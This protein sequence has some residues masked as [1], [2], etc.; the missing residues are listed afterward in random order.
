ML[1]PLIRTIPNLSGNVKIAC[2]LSNFNKIDA[3]SF[4]SIV[5]YAKLLPISNVLAQ[6]QCEVNLMNS[7]YE[8]DLKMFY[9]MYSNTFYNT[10]FTY[11]HKIYGDGDTTK[12]LKNR[13][14]DF[15][16]GLKRVSYKKNGGSQFAFFAP[17]WI[18]SQNDL[19][20]YFLLHINIDKYAHTTTKTIKVL[21]NDIERKDKFNY[22]SLYLNKYAKNL[23]TNVVFCTP[24]T[25]QA[26][27]FGID[28]LHGGFVKKVDNII[29]KNYKFQST[30][31]KFDLNITEGFKRNKLCIKQ[32]MP[33]CFMFSLEDILT[34]YEITKY[35]GSKIQIYGEY[36]KNGQQVKMYDFSTD[37]TLLGQKSW[38]MRNG[39]FAVQDT[40]QN[41]M[42]ISFPSLMEA[43]YQGYE[44]FNKI[45]KESVRWK[46]KYSSDEHPYITNMSPAFSIAQESTCKYREF[47][48]SFSQI[49][50]YDDI[51]N[52]IVSP[53]TDN[54]FYKNDKRALIRYKT[55]MQNNASNWFNVADN[56]ERYT[57]RIIYNLNDL[58]KRNDW[59]IKINGEDINNYIS[60]SYNGNLSNLDPEYFENIQPDNNYEGE[61]FVRCSDTDLRG[62]RNAL[63][64]NMNLPENGSNGNAPFIIGNDESLSYTLYE[65]HTMFDDEENWSNVI[66]NKV[67]FKGILY[68]LSKIYAK[69]PNIN[70][71]TKFG[72]FVDPDMDMIS[73][74]KL[75]DIKSAHFTMF[76]D[77]K[78][79]KHLNAVQCTYLKSLIAGQN[80]FS[81][82]YM[83]ESSIG[84]RM[85]EVS[86]DSLFFEN[87]SQKD[88]QFLDLTRLGYDVYKLNLYFEL[89]EVIRKY[90]ELTFKIY[91]KTDERIINGY[92]QLPIYRLSQV[93]YDNNTLWFESHKANEELWIKNNLFFNL[94]NNQNKSKYDKKAF[95][96]IIA[97]YE[98]YMLECPLL[99]ESQFVSLYT[100]KKL[101]TEEQVDNVYDNCTQYLFN[102]ILVD[103]NE[104][105]G[106]N[107]FTEFKT[108]DKNYGD[109]LP[110]ERK[111]EDIDFIYVDPYN[112]ANVLGNDW[113]S[114]WLEDDLYSLDLYAKFLNKIHLKIYFG[115]LYKDENGEQTIT[116]QDKLD[117]LF[118]KR[119]ILFNDSENER[120]ELKDLYMNILDFYD[121]TDLH[122]ISRK[123][124][125]DLIF[126]EDTGTWSFS[127]E[128]LNSHDIRTLLKFNENDPMFDNY[129]FELVFKRT[130]LKVNKKIWNKININNYDQ[131]TDL[132]LYRISREDDYPA[133]LKYQCAYDLTLSSESVESCYT[134]Q[135]LFTSVFIKNQKTATIYSEYTQSKISYAT[136]NDEH[137]YR[138]D[139]DNTPFVLDISNYD[140]THSLIYGADNT[141]YYSYA[142]LDNLVSSYD[143]YE[144]D[145]AFNYVNRLEQYAGTISYLPTL[146]MIDRSESNVALAHG[147]RQVLQYYA[148][149]SYN[150]IDHIITS[151]TAYYSP[152]EYTRI[153]FNALDS[154]LHVRLG[155][156]N[157]TLLDN[158]TTVH[159]YS[160]DIFEDDV[161][162]Y[163]DL[164]AR[165]VPEK[166]EYDDLGI[167]DE[168]GISTY[169]VT[170]SYNTYYTYT[171]PVKETITIDDGLISYDT[172]RYVTTS[173]YETHVGY[174]TYGMIYIDAKFNNTNTSF[175]LIDKH[176]NDKKYFTYVNN[177]SIY[178]NDFSIQRDFIEF[179]PFM[180]FDLF[181]TLKSTNFVVNPFV[182]TI[183]A[184]NYP[185]QLPNRN[186]YDITMSYKPLCN[187]TLERYFDS[188]TPLITEMSNTS[189]TY[190]IKLENS[191]R[192]IYA[193]PQRDESVLY[194]ENVN[195]YNNNGTRL[196]TDKFN[197]ERVF[198]I[199]DK[200][201]NDNYNVNL[202]S[203]ITIKVSDN[204]TYEQMVEAEKYENVLRLFASYI[205]RN[206]DYDDNE[207]LFLYNKY[208]VSYDSYSTGID[209][210]RICKVYSLTIIFDL[211]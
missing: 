119:R 155:D 172:I 89:K 84:K 1:K 132:Y 25:N 201:F 105:Y 10:Q 211:L 199:E 141:P 34:P 82:I 102:P 205:R 147:T 37:Y 156:H 183:N 47:P 72:V 11:S 73:E 60:I 27:Y 120:V 114:S 32:I 87:T 124:L 88:G 28:L 137:F 20:D 121:E 7:A 112:M 46:L 71:I 85:N 113:N 160:Y 16:F 140:T 14:K 94:R 65:R 122:D 38:L 61:F 52:N 93:S 68:D 163:Y 103:Q 136:Y 109:Y 17:I 196:Y 19:P 151:N 168:F 142:Y 123:I 8:F 56:T 67:Y 59:Y 64:P 48:T 26:T 191:E 185:V 148:E 2:Y 200:H 152:T 169:T 74:N 24:L 193:K 179:V 77:K 207:I 110:E 76:N 203:K 118:I 100:L 127:T 186:A 161:K 174:A 36:W 41:I 106:I 180:K 208:S 30:I 158:G 173:D 23:N 57:K 165:Y 177:R 135:P 187:I 197:Y 170:Y 98:E 130:F 54:T 104:T 75:Y 146:N 3:D 131:F 159:S 162:T 86:H 69:Y 51:N 43:S 154:D 190:M 149:S 126:N 70:K 144:I 204:M 192:H 143:P 184:Y 171:F 116:L 209:Y 164:H 101:F 53:L 45:Q 153:D 90:P 210:D 167:Y 21:V 128:Y 195:I 35:G 92:Y 50:V 166:I 42:N 115:E 40:K 83:S 12:E 6:K 55:I 5:R 139:C 181:N 189:N 91:E 134:L 4:E 108:L 182:N 198:Q 97:K 125:N 80:D 178:A 29:G 133:S 129:E 31:N 138:Y 39:K 62:M 66:D 13:D 9:K 175:N 111:L 95:S 188:I 96:N 157:E 49:S 18:E 150:Y 15:E 44:H 58:E 117:S 145:E 194:N 99:I 79:S 63:R 202:E 22:L 78:Y 33:L 81:S 107:V 206:G 176:H